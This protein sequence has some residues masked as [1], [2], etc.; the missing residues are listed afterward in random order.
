MAYS[1]ADEPVCVLEDGA[2]LV[3][4]RDGGNASANALAQ[5]VLGQMGK[6]GLE[7]TL[8]AGVAVLGTDP[9]DAIAA[10]RTAAELVP[11]GQVGTGS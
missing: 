7:L 10:A 8:T 11:A 6:L 9:T 4:V 2:A 3:L 1:R 5:R